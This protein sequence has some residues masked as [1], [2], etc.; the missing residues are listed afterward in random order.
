MYASDVVKRIQPIFTR[1]F[2]ITFTMCHAS[3]TLIILQRENKNV[4]KVVAKWNASILQIS[5]EAICSYRLKS[6]QQSPSNNG[7][8]FCCAGFWRLQFYLKSN[9]EGQY[10][11]RS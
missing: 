11:T 4:Q 8:T 10:E 6:R 9:C 5:E 3:I 2:S 1:M 7:R